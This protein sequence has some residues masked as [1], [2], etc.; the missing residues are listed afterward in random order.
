MKKKKRKIKYK[1][2]HEFNSSLIKYLAKKY[3][4][5]TS[6]RKN[7]I[8]KEIDIAKDICLTKLYQ[9]NKKIKFKSIQNLKFKIT[10]KKIIMTA[11]LII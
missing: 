1:N 8:Q 9:K 2:E 7:Y 4:E 3:P 11:N 10:S 6:G 5:L